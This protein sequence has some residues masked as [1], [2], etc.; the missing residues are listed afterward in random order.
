MRSADRPE[1]LFALVQ[2][3]HVVTVCNW[4]GRSPVAGDPPLVTI[5]GAFRWSGMS[6][7]PPRRS[8]HC[9]RKELA[10]LAE[11]PGPGS[12]VTPVNGFS[13][14][15]SPIFDYPLTPTNASL[16]RRKWSKLTQKT[17]T[18]IV[19]LRSRFPSL[20]HSVLLI[21]PQGWPSLP[22]GGSFCL[23]TIR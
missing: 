6:D 20:S 17:F 7:Q 14:C 11:T 9:H 2:G 3:L 19:S 16:E 21:R 4:C 5:N 1:S 12:N 23:A 22:V 18:H 8:S 15:V 10:Q 13:P